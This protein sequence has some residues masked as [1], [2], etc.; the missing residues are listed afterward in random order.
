MSL[1]GILPINLIFLY[2]PVS[3]T[4][5][6]IPSTFNVIYR[7]YLFCLGSLLT[8]YKNMPDELLP[9]GVMVGPDVVVWLKLLV[10]QFIVCIPDDVHPV[11]FASR[12]SRISS[13]RFV[14]VAKVKHSC[15][16]N[17]AASVWDAILR[18]VSKNVCGV[19]F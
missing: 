2:V 16:A 15:F 18:S 10:G 19:W 11:L 1:H 4:E 12:G 6:V 17:M 3:Y 5:R 14:Y 8:P 9:P 13:M 7:T